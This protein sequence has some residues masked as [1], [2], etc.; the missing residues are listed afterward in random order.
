MARKKSQKNAQQRYQELS[1]QM[2]GL[3]PHLAS[4]LGEEEDFRE[5]RVKARPDGTM[6]SIAKGYNGDG[7][8]IVAFGSGYGFVGSLLALDATINGGHW[9][10]DVPWVPKSD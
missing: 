3:V 4:W 8:E 1:S 2:Q 5:L 9:K 6:L 10:V 7:G